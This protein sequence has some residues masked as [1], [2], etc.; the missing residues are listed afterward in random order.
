LRLRG[1]TV[2]DPR[3]RKRKEEEGC[4]RGPCAGST[5]RAQ[6]DLR[7]S[8]NPEEFFARFSG[9]FRDLEEFCARQASNLRTIHPSNGVR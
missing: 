3:S 1:R 2:R 9:G 8:I 4:A 5:P 6:K 7:Q